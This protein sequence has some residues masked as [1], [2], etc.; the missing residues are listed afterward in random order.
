MAERLASVDVVIVGVGFTGSI[1]ANELAAAGLSVVALERG[2]DRDTVPDFQAP[3]MHDELR[4]AVRG[5]L[6]QNPAIEAFTFRNNTDQK[7][8]PI[9][10]LGSFLPGTDLGGAGVH[11]NGQTWRFLPSDF[12]L[13][14]HYR[15]RYGAGFVPD[16]LTIQDWPVT[17][18]EL[19]PHYDRFEKLLG[20]GGK[21]GNLRG[22]RRA[23]G[24]PFEGVRQNEFPNPPTEPAYAGAL[25]GNAAAQLG[26]APFQIPTANMTAPYV[27][28]EGMELMA[29]N[30]CGYCERFGCEHFAKSSPQ[31]VILPKVRG[32]SNV[33][34]RMRSHVTRVLL[35]P[36]GRRATGVLYVNDR[37]EEIEQ[38]AE[39]VILCTFGINNVKLM[40]HSGIGRPY[41]PATGEGVVGRNYTYQTMASVNVFYGEDININPFMGAGALGTVIDDFNGDNFDHTGLGF[42]GGAYVGAITS[43]GRPI[44]YHPVPSG[45]PRWGLDWKRAVRRHYNHTVGLSVHGSS[46]ATRGNYLSLDPTYRDSFGVPMLRFTYDFPDNDVRMANYVTDRTVEIAQL[47]GGERINAARR[48][49]P[50]SV[51]PYQT[52]HNTGGAIMGDD[53]ATSATNRYGQVWDVPN[54]FVQGACLY[55]QNPGYNPTGTVGALA[56]WAA[57]AITGRYVREPGPLVR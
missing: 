41:D 24:N 16:E 20:I 18:D 44:E 50:Y 57:E 13:R 30:I 19:E 49:K 22:E 43:G 29:C 28:P 55:P 25:F 21:A 51:V 12:A 37:G 46:M 1:L 7:A 34:M 8:L 5:E 2:V 27:N 48:T 45:T 53:P 40:L 54:V 39:I 26:Y 10:A 42:V 38:P 15:D 9:R 36:D 32:R 52:T 17:Y 6:F 33:E 35:S 3:A 14:S 11:W 31:T 56:Y 47:M 4:Y 23:G